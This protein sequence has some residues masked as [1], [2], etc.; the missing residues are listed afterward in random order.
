MLCLDNASYTTEIVYKSPES[1]RTTLDFFLSDK[2]LGFKAVYR[3][4]F[5]DPD[6]L[7]RMDRM[8]GR[9][10]NPNPEDKMLPYLE[11]LHQFAKQLGSTAELE[12]NEIDPFSFLQ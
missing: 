10:L 11:L 5:N 4:T 1:L 2:T 8:G 12:Y 3:T 6:H 7:R 9:P